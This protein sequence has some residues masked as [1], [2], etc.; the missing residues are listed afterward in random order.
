MRSTKAVPRNTILVR[1]ARVNI[2]FAN[3]KW[4]SMRETTKSVVSQSS[5]LILKLIFSNVALLTL[6]SVCSLSLREELCNSSA[7]ALSGCRS[8]PEIFNGNR[9]LLESSSGRCCS[10]SGACNVNQS[11]LSI[12]AS[13]GPGPPHGLRFGVMMLVQDST[14][15]KSAGTL[16]SISAA[17]C[18]RSVLVQ[19]AWLALVTIEWNTGVFACF[20]LLFL[21]L[22]LHVSACAH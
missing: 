10:G 13:S 12:R 8:Q 18:S 22:S 6:K 11:T 7:L 9:C 4:R 15:I 16:L 1:L 2:H 20:P 19:L 17:S 3:I 14:G 21:C 5:F